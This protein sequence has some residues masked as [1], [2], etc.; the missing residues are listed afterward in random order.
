VQLFEVQFAGS[1]EAEPT[2]GM[3]RAGLARPLKVEHFASAEI[4]DQGV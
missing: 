2:H 1:V 4:G 3:L